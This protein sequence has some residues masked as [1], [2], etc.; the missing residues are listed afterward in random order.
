LPQPFQ[1][2]AAHIKLPGMFFLPGQE[3]KQNCRA[4]HMPEKKAP[5][6]HNFSKQCFLFTGNQP[7]IF[8]APVSDG[9]PPGCF[10]EHLS[11][12]S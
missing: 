8:P 6:F 4:W 9:F 2:P 11:G 12:D 5:L 1:K 3:K 7:R 10:K